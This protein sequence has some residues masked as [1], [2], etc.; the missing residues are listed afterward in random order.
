MRKLQCKI[1]DVFGYW[2]VI[3]NTPITKSGHTYVLVEC[4]CGKQELKNLGD[5]IHGRTTGCRSC[6]ARERSPKINIGDKYKKWTVINGP[7]ITKHHN[8]EWEVQC[9]CGSTRWIQGNEL[10]NPNFCFQC[11]KCAQKERG[12]KEKIKNGKI[13]DLDANQFGKIKR[14]ATN[15]H[16]DF[17]LDIPYLWDLFLQQ[18]KTCAIT[19]D[20]IPDISKASLDRINSNIGYVKGNVQWVTKQANLSKHVMSMYELYEF[21]RKVLD[22]ANQQPSTPLT[23]CEGSETNP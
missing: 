8:I 10:I 22:H 9:A 12:C 21:C 3:D 20:N 19:G 4:K 6:K 14:R 2:K 13:G 15:K 23:K 16:F 5:L 11:T 7:R 17:D 18:N 1:N